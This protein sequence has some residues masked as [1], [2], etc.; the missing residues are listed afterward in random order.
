MNQKKIQWREYSSQNMVSKNVRR[1]LELHKMRIPV[2][3]TEFEHTIVVYKI[4]V[5]YLRVHQLT[6]DETQVLLFLDL[7][8]NVDRKV[9]SQDKNFAK[10]I[11]KTINSYKI[12]VRKYATNK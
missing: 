8:N 4:L 10:M 5:M 7:I 12:I 1:Q 11:V 2:N 9:L 6:N 3:F